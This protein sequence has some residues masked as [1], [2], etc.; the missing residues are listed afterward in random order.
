VQGV[1]SLRTTAKDKSIYVHVFDWP[2]STCEIAGIDARVLSARLLANGRPL[3]FHQSE[4]KLII[5]VPAQ[6]PDPNVSVI[7]LK[8]Y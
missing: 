2:A 5:D 3:T 8:T 7:A 1:T 4:G 6:G